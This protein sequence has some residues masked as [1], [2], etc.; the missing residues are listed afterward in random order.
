MRHRTR[1]TRAT[2]EVLVL[3]SGGLDSAACLAFFAD[4]GQP[5][6]ALHVDY[7]QP[8][9]HNEARAARA[10]A[11]HFGAP[12]EI[13]TVTSA[14]PKTPGLIRG[15]NAFLVAVALLEAPPGIR[16]IAIG[17]HS[18]TA[19]ADCS[20]EF[21]SLMADMAARSTNNLV[22]VSAPFVSCS[23]A[24]IAAYARERGLPFGMTY[25]CEEGRAAPC[26]SCSS[27]LDRKAV[28]AS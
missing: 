23:K 27:C 24:D 26:G 25:S 6:M 4:L 19:Y 2:P 28:D 9:R 22:R 21:V 14:L 12:L 20:P 11:A 15:R 17:V 18:G 7:G 16:T 10:V 5:S 3:L 13:R 1:T 8:A